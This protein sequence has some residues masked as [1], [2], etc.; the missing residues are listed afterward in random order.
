[1]GKNRAAYLRR[2]DKYKLHDTKVLERKIRQSWL[3]YFIVKQ[4]GII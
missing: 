2:G 3:P 1:M 4:Q